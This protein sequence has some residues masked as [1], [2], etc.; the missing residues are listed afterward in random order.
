MKWFRNLVGSANKVASSRPSARPSV[1][2]LEDR[3]L[4]AIIVGIHLPNV[5]V[6]FDSAGKM[7]K[8]VVFAGAGGNVADNNAYIFNPDG[9]ATFLGKN[10]SLVHLYRDANGKIGMDIVYNNLAN[11]PAAAPGSNGAAFEFDSTGPGR[12]VGTNIDD[13]SRSI[14]ANGNFRL[15]VVYDDGSGTGEGNLYEYTKAGGTPL[16]GKVFF[17]TSYLD[18]KGALGLAY[19]RVDGV[20]FR[21]F[22]FD[23]TGG[24]ALGLNVTDYEQGSNP[25]SSTN[26][27][28][29][30]VI[31]ETFLGGFT[32]EFT[33]P[34][35]A[36]LSASGGTIIA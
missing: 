29:T 12:M 33:F 4:P 16:A 27:T 3:C 35:G 7:S 10:I 15:E 32:Q 22:A 19:G 36:A 31:D 8:A 23:S 26:T 13:Y 34:G 17:A 5:S 28:A 18:S 9:T 2:A 1:E 6:A 11:N 20:A 25:V 14:D 21:S 24:R 30:F